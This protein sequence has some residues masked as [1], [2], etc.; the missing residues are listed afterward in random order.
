MSKLILLRGLPA[1]GKST[2]AKEIVEGGGNF[3]RLNRDLIREMLHFNKW[4]HKNEGL[5]V[6]AEKHLAREFLNEDVN[7]IIDDCNLSGSHKDMW[8]AVAD[9]YSAKFEIVD[10]TYIHPY[11]C[12]KRDIDRGTKVG[13]NVIMNMA[14]QYE[15]YKPKKGYIIC[16]LDG[17]LCDITHRLEFVKGEG[18][19]DWKSFFWHIPEDKLKLD[20]YKKL[21]SYSEEGYDIVFVSARPQDY[22]DITVKWL[23]KHLGALPWETLI[24][25]R[26]GDIRDDVDVKRDILNR[27]FKDRSLIHKVID[28][29][30]R[31]VK[32]WQEELGED[33][34]IDV[35]PGP[36]NPF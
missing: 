11:E 34:V 10:L 28:D 16:D 5:T 33:R 15:L 20:T 36:D 12:V 14:L 27:F 26:A 23:N 18:K 19:K 1:S 4:S 2:R 22:E 35:G 31:V 32:V 8:R 25:R 30:P 6:N 29:R 3:I 17:T 7:V 24:M 21:C 9:K 13:N